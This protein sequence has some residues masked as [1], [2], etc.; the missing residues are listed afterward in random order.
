MAFGQEDRSAG[1]PRASHERQHR[2]GHMARLPPPATSTMMAPGVPVR[3]PGTP[4][5]TDM[6]RF[7]TRAGMPLPAAFLADT[8]PALYAAP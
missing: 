8:A 2:F 6:H 1:W 5:A 3:V 4:G 7:S